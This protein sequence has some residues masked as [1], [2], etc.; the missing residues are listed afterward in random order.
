MLVGSSAP[1][2]H[3]AEPDHPGRDQDVQHGP[4]AQEWQHQHGGQEGRDGQRDRQRRARGWPRR[5]MRASVTKAMRFTIVSRPSE[6]RWRPIRIS[7]TREHDGDR[8]RGRS[9]A[10]R[11]DATPADHLE[12]TEQRGRHGDSPNECR[13][14]SCPVDRD[15]VRRSARAAVGRPVCRPWRPSCGD[16]DGRTRARWDPLGRHAAA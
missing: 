13:E 16:R 7:H 12:D 11:R 1:D 2:G 3:G 15:P 10:A 6:P 14:L 4:P 9:P 5:A 8:R